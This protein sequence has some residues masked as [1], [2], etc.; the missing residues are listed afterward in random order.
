MEDDALP[1]ASRTLLFP[2]PM[3][4]LSHFGVTLLR[5]VV[6]TGLRSAFHQL[7]LPLPDQAPVRIFR[8]RLYFDTNA[9]RL[10]LQNRSDINAEGYAEAREILGALIDPAGCSHE[11]Q[12]ISRL[13][14]ALWFHRTRLHLRGCPAPRIK[15]T[16][17]SESS[18]D[19]IWS[20]ARQTLTKLLPPLCDAFLAE[21]VA[22]VTRRQQRFRGIHAPPCLGREAAKWVG[23]RGAR[24]AFLGAPDPLVSSWEDPSVVPTRNHEIT[25]SASK[26]PIHSL[27]GRFREQ[28]RA[29]LNAFRSQ[30]EVLCDSAVRRNII[31]RLSDAYFLPFDLAGDLAAKSRPAWLAGA[32]ATNRREY[33]A[34][35]SAPSPPDLLSGEAEELT[36]LTAP[37]D[38]TTSPLNPMP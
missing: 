4:P 25:S 23:D 38:W 11:V 18:P 26:V 36:G 28:Y 21:V 2:G 1:K 13:R 14:G 37:Q 17:P 20:A 9:L 10:L 19:Q 32:I 7:G 12:S 34:L 33:E 30:Y 29:A 15:S 6:I 27:R 16:L 5:H 24:P 31:E 3:A 22:S 35:Q 8:L